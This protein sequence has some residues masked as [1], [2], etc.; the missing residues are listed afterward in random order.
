LKVI[1]HSIAE[2]EKHGRG[3]LLMHDIK[4]TTAGAL[5]VLFAELKRRGFRIVHVVPESNPAPDA[6]KLSRFAQK[7]QRD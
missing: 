1:E 7:K 4:P 2:L 3:I 6:S 5:P